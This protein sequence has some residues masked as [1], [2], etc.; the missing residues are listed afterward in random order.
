MTLAEAPKPTTGPLGLKSIGKHVLLGCFGSDEGYHPTF[1]AT[2]NS[3]LMTNT[4]CIA[5]CGAAGKRYA[6]VQAKYALP[7]F[8][9]SLALN[10]PPPQIRFQKMLTLLLFFFFFPLVP[11][12]APHIW[13]I[14]QRST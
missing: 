9:R 7:P 4:M 14:F 10:V 12:S 2:A 1:E 5:K 11:V 3:T 13:A 6:G 8:L